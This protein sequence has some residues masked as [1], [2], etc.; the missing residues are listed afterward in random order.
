MIESIVN[1]DK[2]IFIF[3]NN[4]GSE[5]WDFLFLSLSNKITMFLVIIFFIIIHSY[6][7]NINRVLSFM[8]FFIICV[9]LTDFLH[10]RL[11]KNIFMRLRPCWENDI[12]SQ[13]RPLLLDCGG[14]YGFIS[15]HAANS[16]AMVTFLIYCF[17]NQRTLIKYSLLIWMLA[18]SYSR[19]YLAKHYPLDVLFGISFGFLIGVFMFNIYK[20]YMN[21]NHII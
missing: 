2:K 14:H 1:I 8:L 17:K 10:V 3:L 18:V 12:L 6:K 9:A 19:I 4:L 13:I 11:F 5:K 16:A 7:M 15:G 20:I 21:K